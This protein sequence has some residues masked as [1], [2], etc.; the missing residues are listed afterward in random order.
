MVFQQIILAASIR[1]LALTLFVIAV[2]YGAPSRSRASDDEFTRLGSTGRTALSQLD[3]LSLPACTKP[4]TILAAAIRPAAFG[5]LELSDAAF[6]APFSFATL[7]LRGTATPRWIDLQPRAMRAW[8]LTPTFRIGLASSL[9]VTSASGFLPHIE[10]LADVHAVINL[11]SIWTVSC[12]VVNAVRIGSHFE[13]PLRGP[14]IHTAVARSIG[15]FVASVDVAFVSGQD[16]GIMIETADVRSEMLR[17]RASF[18]TSPFA[19]SAAVAIPL[20][21]TMTLVCE[22][23]HVEHLGYRTMLGV[24]FKP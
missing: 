20:P 3:L 12:L 15:D 19:L 24:E 23:T 9:H 7:S 22:C 13:S 16:V 10:V 8:F 21:N 11:D 2:V 4:D 17:W 14:R 6:V 18:C 5:L 1:M